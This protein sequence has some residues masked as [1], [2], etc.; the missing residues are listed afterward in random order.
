MKYER[1]GSS[2]KYSIIFFLSIIQ[3]KTCQRVK[4]FVLDSVNIKVKKY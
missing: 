2:D 3:F 1:N 4:L